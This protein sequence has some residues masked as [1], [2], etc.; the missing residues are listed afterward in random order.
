MRVQQLTWDKDKPLTIQL[1][2]LSCLKCSS[3]KSCLHYDLGEI[4]LDDQLAT[5]SQR[6]LLLL[7]YYSLYLT[8]YNFIKIVI[9]N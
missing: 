6:I 8:G 9:I 4:K 3:S 1:R 2:S 7:N 5:P